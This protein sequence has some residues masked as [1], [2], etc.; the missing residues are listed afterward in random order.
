MSDDIL[1]NVSISDDND[2]RPE[3]LTAEK[4]V[5]AAV[6]ARAELGELVSKI[7]A[8]DADAGEN[9]NVRYRLFGPA[10]SFFS[11]DYPT[12]EVTVQRRLASEAGKTFVL[13]VEARDRSGRE[14]GLA[15]RIDLVVRI[16][17]T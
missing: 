12:G 17:N 6:E 10:K 16:E 9:A 2:N 4:P 15:T 8:W 5:V 13:E 11:I 1:I 14:D 3:F 7:E